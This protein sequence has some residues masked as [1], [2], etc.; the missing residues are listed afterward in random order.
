M[1]YFWESTEGEKKKMPSL[2]SKD[3]KPLLDKKEDKPIQTNDE[4]TKKELLLEDIFDSPENKNKELHIEDSLGFWI[5]SKDRKQLTRTHKRITSPQIESYYVMYHNDKDIGGCRT[6]CYLLTNGSIVDVAYDD[7]K[8]G[9]GMK[10][11][12]RDLPVF[13]KYVF[14]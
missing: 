13:T 9:I 1:K 2:S 11:N 5:I 6:Y 8:K 7:D 4:P 3:M 14:K 12:N 10:I